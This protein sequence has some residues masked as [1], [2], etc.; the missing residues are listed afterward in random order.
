[1]A[2][3]FRKAFRGVAGGLLATS[4]FAL[5]SAALPVLSSPA[6]AQ[7]AQ[8]KLVTL[9]GSKRSADFV[10]TGAA[11][12]SQDK[13]AIIVWGGNRVLQQEAYNAALDLRDAGIDVAFIIGPD[14]NRFDVD[15]EFQVYARGVPVYEGNGALFG[16]ANAHEVRPT[17]I[18]MGRNAHAAHFSTQ[19]TG[20]QP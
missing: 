7:T 11:A 20:Q 9:D 2:N 18:R 17:V 4:A 15:A 12:A 8:G 5:P 19:T 6:M 3:I 10:R 14:S 1:M 16:E 13:I